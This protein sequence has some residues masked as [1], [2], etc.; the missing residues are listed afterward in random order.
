MADPS[1]QS[2]EYESPTSWGTTRSG[3][4]LNRQ[5]VFA[6]L[7]KPPAAGCGQ[8]H[9]ISVAHAATSPRHRRDY[10]RVW[11]ELCEFLGVPT[12]ES[13]NPHRPL[14]AMLVKGD[15]E[16]NLEE[17]ALRW[18]VY[19]AGVQKAYGGGGAVEF[20]GAFSRQPNMPRWNQ[21]ARGEGPSGRLPYAP[22]HSA[23]ALSRAEFARAKAG[24]L[25]AHAFGNP[26]DGA[27]ALCARAWGSRRC[28]HA[29]HRQFCALQV[30]RNMALAGTLRVLRVQ[31][32]F[33]QRKT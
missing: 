22:E 19:K 31:R 7:N 25:G 14:P 33:F 26:E 17:L 18:L 2:F 9:G 10:R 16:N 4:D 11:I 27:Y 32:T 13:G 6:S 30:A 8:W 3:Q 5:R 28:G 1:A 21:F 24:N 12:D 20:E 23:R 15:S 29:Q